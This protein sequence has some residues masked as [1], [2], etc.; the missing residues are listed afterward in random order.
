MTSNPCRPLQ[1]AGGAAAKG[2]GVPAGPE[3]DAAA[4]VSRH[5]AGQSPTQTTR[6]TPWPIYRLLSHGYVSK[7]S[8]FPVSDI[9]PPSIFH[10]PAD[11]E[12]DKQLV[13]WLKEQGADAD[14]IDKVRH[15]NCVFILFVSTD[16]L[17]V[18]PL[19]FLPQF[20]LDE[21][22]LTDILTDVT[23]DDLRP[24]RLR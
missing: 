7:S 11:H 13:D 15:L 9:S 8:L 24:L 14:T 3:G 5:G 21:Y 12:P 4:E 16:S 23:K 2:E 6:W 10:V 20:V 18:V 19:C 1:A 22:T 17:T